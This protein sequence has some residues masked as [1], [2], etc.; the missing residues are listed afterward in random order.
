M[1]SPEKVG[2]D[3]SVQFLSVD[4]GSVVKRS[5]PETVSPGSRRGIKVGAAVGDQGASIKMGGKRKT[6]VMTVSSLA[7]LAN[8]SAVDEDV[9]SITSQDVEPPFR[10]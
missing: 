10:E 3:E 5:A 6:I 8:R 7:S 4:L 9:I 2:S 1:K